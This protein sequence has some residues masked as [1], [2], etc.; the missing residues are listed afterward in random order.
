MFPHATD[1][2]TIFPALLSSFDVAFSPRQE[3]P[4][5]ALVLLLAA[6]KPGGPSGG[7]R[8]MYGVCE[9]KC[10]HEQARSKPSKVT[11]VTDDNRCE[12]L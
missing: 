6:S 1:P 10:R 9:G 5:R 7:E 12:R 2:G 4:P 8:F 3:I 11:A